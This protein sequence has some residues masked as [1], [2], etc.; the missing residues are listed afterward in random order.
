LYA[1]LGEKPP[2]LSGTRLVGSLF[3]AQNACNPAGSLI[4]V[5]LGKPA[6]PRMPMGGECAVQ[7][8]WNLP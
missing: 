1:A 7:S 2:P 6:V 8:D 4:K 5:Y 3:L